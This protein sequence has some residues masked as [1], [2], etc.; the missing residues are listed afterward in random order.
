MTQSFEKEPGDYLKGSHKRW[1]Y[2]SCP[3]SLPI[4]PARKAGTQTT[5]G[6]LRMWG[7]M[8]IPGLQ[9]T[10][11][12]FSHV[13]SI[14]SSPMVIPWFTDLSI[15]PHIVGKESGRKAGD[16]ELLL[17][18]ID[19]W[20]GILPF[21]PTRRTRKQSFSSLVWGIHQTGMS[22][23]IGSWFPHSLCTSYLLRR[24]V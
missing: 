17:N 3:H 20:F 9:M 18:Q 22:C 2:G 6:A 12:N 19:G 11:G 23:Q 24:P 5:F 4:A 13:G 10:M 8:N 1:L 16:I 14:R 7:L 21:A 15:N